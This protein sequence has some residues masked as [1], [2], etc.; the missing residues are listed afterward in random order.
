MLGQTRI[1]DLLPRAT[2]QAVASSWQMAVEG[3]VPY[4]ALLGLLALV[5]V[6]GAA[7]VY[8]MRKGEKEAAVDTPIARQA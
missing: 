6:V 5:A 1:C 2:S 3:A 7:V 8:V 4:L